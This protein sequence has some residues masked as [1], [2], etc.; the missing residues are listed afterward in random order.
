MSTT[1]QESRT[2]TKQEKNPKL[3]KDRIEAMKYI[4]LKPS[5]YSLHY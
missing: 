3:S 5:H 2:L 1:K 4:R